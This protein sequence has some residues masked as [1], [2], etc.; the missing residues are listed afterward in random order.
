MAVVVFAVLA[1]AAEVQAQLTFTANYTGGTVQQQTATT[2]AMNSLAA[3]FSNSIN[4]KVAVTITDLGNSSTLGSSSANF[5]QSGTYFYATPL[6]NAVTSTDLA[7]ATTSVTITMNTNSGIN[8]GY[9]ASAPGAGNYSWQS[10]VMHEVIHSMGF[11]DGITD[12]T[13]GLANAGYTIFDSFTVR[14]PGNTAFTSFTTNAQRATAITSNQ[15]YWNGAFGKAANGG[16]PVQ[17]FAPS[18]FATGSTYSHIDPSQTGVGGLLF[19]ALA[20][21]TFYA[22]PTAVELGIMRD[23]GWTLTAVPEPA[24]LA[25]ILGSFGLALAIRHRRRSAA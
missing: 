2:A 17:L 24:T 22:G 7:G 9:A 13:G 8:W 16:N 20:D 18:T 12:A 1:L 14:N 11:Y 5:S 25:L 10:V 15:L 6:F 21:N 19:P 4:L 3:F 23:M